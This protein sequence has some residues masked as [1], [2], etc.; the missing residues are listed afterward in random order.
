MSESRAINMA[1]GRVLLVI[2]TLRG[3]DTWRVISARKARRHE[4][5]WYY[6]GDEKDG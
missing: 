1:R 3:D 5:N 2:P 6:K 4:E